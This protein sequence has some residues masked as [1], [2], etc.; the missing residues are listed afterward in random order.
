MDDARVEIA[1]RV[2]KVIADVL[3]V[4]DSDMIES[5][6]LVGDLEAD[7]LEISQIAMVLEEEFDIYIPDE[8]NDQP[9][10]IGDTIE[11]IID[12]KKRN[13]AR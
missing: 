2:K 3:D 5:A 8:W 1:H 10:T 13:G 4:D 11:F 7:S 12:F 9:L 6:S